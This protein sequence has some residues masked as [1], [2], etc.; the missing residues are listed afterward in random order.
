V[1]IDE[2]ALVETKTGNLSLP[3]FSDLDVDISSVSI[4]STETTVSD[5]DIQLPGTSISNLLS[6]NE[7]DIWSYNILTRK[8][9]TEP[10]TL[11]IEVNLGDKKE[12]NKILISPN[13]GAPCYLDSM[14][15][16]NENEEE[17]DM[18]VESFVLTEDKIF[19]FPTVIAKKIKI[20]FKQDKAK[21]IPL[22]ENANQVTVEDLQRDPS[23]PVNIASI[24]D[25]IN[26]QINDP[27]IQN[28]LGL[29]QIRVTN[30]ILLNNYGFSLQLVKI[31]K[32]DYKSK[33]V[34]VSKPISLNSPVLISL[35]A[36][37][38]IVQVTDIQTGE[39]MPSG[40]IEYSILKKD[41]SAAGALLKTSSF[42]I[43][44]LGQS[45]IE[46]EFLDL[47]SSKIQTL[48]FLGH[49]T[50]GDGSN[51]KVYRNGELLILGVDWV[52]PDRTNVVDLSSFSIDPLKGQ[53]RIEL[54]HGTDQISNGIYYAE[55]S[56]RYILEP[57]NEIIDSNV[58]YLE[59]GA[60]VHSIDY[61]G[62]E[63]T[64]SDVFIKAI[65][66]N[67]TDSGVSSPFLEYYRI[68]VKE[69]ANE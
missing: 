33:G 65:I 41:Y 12:I 54:L 48:R 22:D 62:E 45:L 6:D 25:N 38:N 52:F 21:V 13:A 17:I 1:K 39:E 20:T 42:S 53:T 44:P 55:Y 47:S 51:V 19:N 11:S 46:D 7:T 15:Y 29:D 67:H 9:L 68:L 64:K 14:S 32:S 49:E 57:Q 10:A 56:P 66:R 58:K 40:S 30:H 35:E 50:N 34:Y 43:I 36:S 37:K 5:F 61:F 60:T 59:S 4:I 2:L 28:I 31:G 63:I 24:S 69:E 3:V 26:T 23:L 18:S 16:T 27:N 8:K